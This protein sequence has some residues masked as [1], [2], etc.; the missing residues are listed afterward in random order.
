M[1]PDLKKLWFSRAKKVVLRKK[2]KLLSSFKDFS[3]PRP[4]SIKVR[5]LNGHVWKTSAYNLVSSKHWCKR[6]KLSDS[7]KSRLPSLKEL[8]T[9]AFRQGGRCLSKIYLGSHTHL[10][11]KCRKG[12][13]W[14]AKPTNIKSGKWCPECRYE[15]LSKRFRTKN[16]LKKYAAIAKERG[17]FLLTRKAQKNASSYAKWKCRQGYVF[18]AKINNV[19][20]GRWCRTCSSGR[21]ER[22]VRSVFEQAFSAPFPSSWPDWLNFKGT[23]RQLDGYNERLKLAFEHQ[24]F[25]HY[26]PGFK[27]GVRGFLSIRAGD[28]Y[29]KT[30][31]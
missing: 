8:K 28:K 25:Q 19:I 12:H 7:W 20:N 23:R 15:K 6:C 21:G 16:A 5:C 4:P 9:I 26:R 3:G 11:W 2:G 22:I 24:G 30:A 29:K 13:V 17:G 14:E 10:K 31:C 18:L 27:T 1:K